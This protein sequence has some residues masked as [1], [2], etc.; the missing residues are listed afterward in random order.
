M[1]REAL[2][3]LENRG[4]LDYLAGVRRWA[5]EVFDFA[6]AHGYFVGDNPA[7]ALRKKTYSRSTRAAT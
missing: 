7:H 3:K 2:R 1:L 4:A 5:G 6:K